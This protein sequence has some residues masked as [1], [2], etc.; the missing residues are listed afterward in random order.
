[1]LSEEREEWEFL[2]SQEFG[3]TEM[4]GTWNDLQAVP[5]YVERFSQAKRRK[6]D[7]MFFYYHLACGTWREDVQYEQVR[8]AD[9]APDTI[10]AGCWGNLHE[11]PPK[12][13]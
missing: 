3:G 5:S 10:C 2:L 1:M 8:L 9:C 6:L 13:D 7:T 12:E 4:Q 11:A